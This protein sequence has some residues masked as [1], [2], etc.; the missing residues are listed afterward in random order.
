MRALR[1]EAEQYLQALIF[2]DQYI[3][4]QFKDT[5]TEDLLLDV[6]A[7]SHPYAPFVIGDLSS[8]VGIYHTNPKLFYVPKQNTLGHYNTEFGDELYMIEE[9][10]S[11]GHSDLASFGYQNEL[12]S[13]D[14][15][16]D[17][18]HEDGDNIVDEAAYIRARLFDMLI[19]D[20]DR[21]QDQWRWIEFK[22]N[23]R[24]VYRPMPRD[25]DQ[26]FS[27]MA[28]G[29][30]LGLAVKIIPAAKLLRVYSDDLV[31]VKSVNVEPYPLDMELIQQSD[32]KVWDAQVKAIQEGITDAVIEQAFL[33]MPVEVRD[34]SV[35]DI[36][37]KLKA[38]RTNLGLIYDYFRMN[39]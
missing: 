26:A 18:L 15:M 25:R 8:A 39:F 1:K 5:A 21:H 10:T 17:E 38:R 34:T 27:K 2:K 22:E 35:E 13:T 4:G 23:G 24:K 16:M 29:F 36:K 3:E 9:H 32:R 28:D 14:D 12:L 37:S 19:G 6:F 33:N 31:D 30:L 11:E 20:W 7:G